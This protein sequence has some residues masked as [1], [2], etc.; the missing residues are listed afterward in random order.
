M[1]PGQRGLSVIDVFPH[2]NQRGVLGPWERVAAIKEENNI[3]VFVFQL[4]HFRPAELSLWERNVSGS[5]TVGH[6]GSIRPH[7][8]PAVWPSPTNLWVL[9]LIW[10]LEG[11][12]GPSGGVGLRS[13][14]RTA[15]Q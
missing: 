1:D 6:F 11:R 12:L 13:L 15:N 5:D 2:T 7:M 8:V 14:E 9:E 10:L 4:S 3:S